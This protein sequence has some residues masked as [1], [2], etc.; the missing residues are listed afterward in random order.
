MDAGEMRTGS[1]QRREPLPNVGIAPDST[2]LY[3]WAL[4]RFL[5]NL[6]PANLAD[7]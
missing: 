1:G 5:L 4:R 3:W 6:V 7:F 2:H